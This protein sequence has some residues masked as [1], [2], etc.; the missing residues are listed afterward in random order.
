MIRKRRLVVALGF[1]FALVAAPAL[2]E[3]A[4]E[5]PATTEM[6]ALIETLEDDAARERLLTQLRLLLET[7]EAVE[8]EA[9]AGLGWAALGAFSGRLADLSEGFADLFAQDGGVERIGSWLGEQFSTPRRRELWIEVIWKLAVVV[10]AGLV[11]RALAVAALGR[12][13]RRLEQR[14]APT[15]WVRAPLLAAR[16][17]LDLVPIGVFAGAAY[18]ALAAVQPGNAV[19]LV[20]VAAISAA[21]IAWAAGAAARLTFTPLAPSLRLIS[22][23]DRT[24]A[25]LYVWFRRLVRIAVY[26]TFAVEAALALGLPA[27]GGQAILKLVGLLFAALVLVFILQNRA[28]VAQWI[29]GGAAKDSERQALRVIRNR[30]ADVWHILAVLYLIAVTVVWVL[31]GAGGFAFV[32]RASALSLLTIV[33]ARLALA[34]LRHAM[35]WLFR[36]SSEIKARYPYVEAR[37]ERYVAGL[38]RALE[39]IVYVIAALAVLQSWDIGV[40]TF[41][42]GETGRDLLGRAF[43]IVAIVVVALVVWEGTSSLI[44]R[45]LTADADAEGAPVERSA[46]ARTLLPLARSV[47]LVV[48]VIVAGLTVLSALGINIAPLLAG[49][50]VVGLAVGFGA[51]TLVKDVITGAFLLFEDTVQVG[52]VAV[53]NGQG[54]LVEAITIR[55]IRLRDLAGSVHTIPFSTVGA[56][57]NMTKEYSRYVLDVGVAYRED[58]DRVAELLREIDADLRADPEFGQHILQPIE[59]LG[60]DRFEDSAVVVRARLTT[61]PIMQWTVG[62]EFNRRLKKKF[63]EHGI[64]IPFPH[65]TIYFGEDKQGRAP[66]AH[67]RVDKEGAKYT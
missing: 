56:I 63:D 26:G 38:S 60:V 67:I 30:F 33:I 28:A 42:G 34:A 57:T 32:A 19:R 10:A 21:V 50:G 58:T 22:L 44:A 8:T 31:D 35:D 65:Q 39:W 9:S 37:A 59:I 53:I 29:R 23:D 1:T 27:A 46:R 55:T 45:Y 17:V 12:A 11:A 14:D 2:G 61:K 51:Q 25:Y 66:V 6:R 7:R 5:A 47:L 64:E 16:T 3:T 36:V 20:A 4:G 15:F 24:A 52:D 62:R 54:G 18:I 49:A 13:R 41:L 43:Q 48:I 40:L